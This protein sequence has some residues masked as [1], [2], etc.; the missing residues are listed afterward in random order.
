MAV[1][2]CSIVSPEGELFSGE[3]EMLI[4]EGGSGEVAINPRHAPLLATLKPGPLRLTMEGGAEEVFYAS[5][6]FIEVQP[7]SVTVLTDVAERATD[8]DEAEAERAKELAEKE[9]EGQKADLDY[10]LAA[11]QLAEAAARLKSIQKLRKK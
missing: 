7:G 6:G 4:A 11:A 5:G 10:S 3:V 9:L 2:N 8:I 1:I